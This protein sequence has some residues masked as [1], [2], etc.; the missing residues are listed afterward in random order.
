MLGN[1]T[2]TAVV[3]HLLAQGRVPD[4]PPLT[5]HPD[6]WAPVM[7]LLSAFERE[8]SGDEN[9]FP[10]AIDEEQYA[11][12]DL[13]RDTALVKNLVDL[14]D[15]I[16]DQAAAFAALEWNRTVLPAVIGNG[17]YGQ[18]FAADYR[19]IDPELWRSDP[20]MVIRGVNRVH[21]AA[22]LWILQRADQ[23]VDDW[24]G[25]GTN[26]IFTQYLEKQWNWMAVLESS[27]PGVFAVGD[28]RAG[29]VKRVASAVG[30]GAISVS[31]LHRALAEL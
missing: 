19:K 6:G 9:I 25:M 3:C 24:P 12:E 22:P 18:F 31:M 28:V 29:S 2:E 30:E 17:K 10:M 16:I 7:Q 20:F 15:G 21:T 4:H 8:W 23:R 5:N 13:E 14:S 26:P 27:L 1:A 11:K